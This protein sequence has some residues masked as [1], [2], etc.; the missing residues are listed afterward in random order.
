[1]NLI[2]SIYKNIG[3]NQ[4]LGYMIVFARFN[5]EN[6]V[7]KAGIEIFGFSYKGSMRNHAIHALL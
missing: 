1:L 7:F 4:L 3:L 5:T 2:N 6:P